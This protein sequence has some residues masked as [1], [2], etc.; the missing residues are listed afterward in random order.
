MPVTPRKR[1]HVST[2]C[3]GVGSEIRRGDIVPEETTAQDVVKSLYPSLPR[4]A[5]APR[6]SRWEFPGL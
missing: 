3:N 5:I 1:S 6:L 2:W 4:E